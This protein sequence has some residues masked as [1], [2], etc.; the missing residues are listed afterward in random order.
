MVSEISY[1]NDSSGP[2]PRLAVT[3]Q[4]LSETETVVIDFYTASSFTIVLLFVS[5]LLNPSRFAWECLPYG[6]W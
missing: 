5:S 2:S 3:D 1:T 6:D 4:P